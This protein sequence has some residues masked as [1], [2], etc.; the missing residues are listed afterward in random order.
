MVPVKLRHLPDYIGLPLFMCLR[1]ISQILPLHDVP[2]FDTLHFAVGNIC[3]RIP[4]K[5]QDFLN[6]REKFKV[7]YTYQ[8]PANAWS[9]EDKQCLIDTI[10]RGEP[11]PLFFLNSVD[12]VFYIVDGQQRLDCI[13]R[14]YNNKI[15]LNA[16]FSGEDN[17]GKT[18]G[19]NTPISDILKQNFLDYDLKFHIVENYDDS[20][21][22]MLFSRL[23]RGKPLSLGERL[24][25]MPGAIVDC[26]WV[27]SSH[28]F[29]AKSITV[30]QDR[31]GL[32]PDV[33]RI[34]LYAKYGAKDSGSESLYAFFNKNSDLNKNHAEFKETVSVLNHLAKCFPAEPGNYRHLEKHT[35]VLAVFTM[36]HELKKH[37]SLLD[38]H[39]D[40]GKFIKEFHSRVYNEDFRKSKPN[41]QRFYDRVR[42]GWSENLIASRRDI[43]IEEFLI[44]HP[45]SKLDDFRQISNE[46]KIALFATHPIC[47]RCGSAFKDYA[48]AEYH[49]IHHYADGGESSTDNIMVLC[50][51]CHTAYHNG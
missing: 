26:M 27:L 18:F 30:S 24:N 48:A 11:M 13:S 10:L 43:L 20:R 29:M 19:G 8:R 16:K 23:Q 39:G 38:H 41:Y 51:E 46:Q 9:S 2:V 12:G 17:A 36:M 14:F 31:Y 22:R 35:W 33:A 37:Y 6:H 25:A 32:F 42:G 50:G 4:M 28:I 5:I 45:L 44:K 1:R 34:L 40:V 15:K 47:Q 21:I 49:H 3:Q 7:D